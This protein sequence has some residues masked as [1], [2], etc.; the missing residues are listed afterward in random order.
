MKK[1]TSL[2]NFRK[3]MNVNEKFAI[4]FFIVDQKISMRLT[5]E[6]F[7]HFTKIV[8]RVFHEMFQAMNTFY[9]IFVNIF[10]VFTSFAFAL[11]NNIKFWSFFKNCVET[12]N[13]THVLT[14]MLEKRHQSYRNRKIIITQNVL[15]MC[16]FDMLFTYMLIDWKKSTND[17]QILKNAQYRKFHASNDKYYLKNAN[18]SN[19]SFILISYRNV[20]YHLKKQFKSTIKSQN[21]KKLFNFRHVFLRNHI[22]RSFEIFKRRFKI[23]R[24]FSKYSL[25]I[26]TRLMYVL[27]A[28]NNFV[29]KFNFKQNKYQR[30]KF[31]KSFETKK[32]YL[33]IET[34]D[35]DFRIMNVKRNFITTN[36][37][38]SYYKYL[39]R[40]IAA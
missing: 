1:Y 10:I 11:R 6:T 8:A 21:K 20:K 3:S 2:K 9:T 23:F 4:F 7:R 25:Q 27:I 29:N 38:K 30:E 32:N 37:W 18:Y 34:I 22:E 31:R 19:T 17:Q 33:S 40:A 26:Q 35:F 15:T 28:L 14:H 24:F 12:L 36:M 39:S 16:D 13:E 5:I